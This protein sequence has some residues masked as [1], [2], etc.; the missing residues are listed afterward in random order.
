MD[1]QIS[2]SCLT[3]TR[4]DDQ[5]T[6]AASD[7]SMDGFNMKVRCKESVTGFKLNVFKYFEIP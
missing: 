7:P 2:H 6:V 4:L 3:H 1:G 5:Y